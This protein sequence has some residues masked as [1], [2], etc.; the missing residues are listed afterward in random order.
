MI[1][2]VM[3]PNGRYAL[4]QYNLIQS[5]GSVKRKWTSFDLQTKEEKNLK[6]LENKIWK[7]IH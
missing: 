5:D 3:A 1:D 6:K 2:F 4:V 7:L